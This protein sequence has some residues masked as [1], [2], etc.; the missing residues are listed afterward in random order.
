MQ[1]PGA[2][3]DPERTNPVMRA[4]IRA[5]LSLADTDG[6]GTVDKG[7]FDRWAAAQAAAGRQPV[8]KAAL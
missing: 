1:A 5:I 8:R 6:D 2:N 3:G 4:L 7:E